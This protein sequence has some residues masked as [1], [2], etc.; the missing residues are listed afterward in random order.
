ML[1]QS[2]DGQI[3][4]L[5][6]L[7]NEWKNGSIKGI[8]ARGNF[9]VDIK[10]ENGQLLESK[11]YSA[12]DGNCRLRTLQPVKVVEVKSFPAKG[13]NPNK[14]MASYGAPPYE[15]NAKAKLVEVNTTQ[16]YVID[17]KTEQGKT[18]TIIPLKK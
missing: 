11:I 1:L 5:P 13:D 7:P 4:L 14:L 17:F 9:M 10:W 8:K 15:K 18:Y 2:H 12:L 16:G 3:F 6:A